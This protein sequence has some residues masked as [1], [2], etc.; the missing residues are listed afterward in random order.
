MPTQA[1]ASPQATHNH[2]AFNLVAIAVMAAA[3]ALALAYGIDAF[4]KHR[5]TAPDTGTGQTRLV[6][7]IAG[8]MLTIPAGWMRFGRDEQQGFASQIDL[9]LALPLG[10]VDVTLLPRSRARTSAALLDGVY[11]HRFLPEE[12]PGPPGLVGKPLRPAEGFEGETVWYD[13]LS[14][15][16]FVAKCMDAVDGQGP[17]QCLRTVILETG[18]AAVYSFSAEAL[19][20]WREFDSQVAVS[21]K[22]IGAL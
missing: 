16:P 12:V 17:A 9:R 8:H 11:L 7:N 2:L 13:P 14:G 4:G 1:K 22:A 5:A 21:L 18:L 3:G 19:P 6:R 10:P 15:S 20:A